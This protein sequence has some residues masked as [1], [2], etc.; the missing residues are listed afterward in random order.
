MNKMFRLSALLVAITAVALADST[1]RTVQY[2]AKDIVNIR[3]KVKYT[4]LIE[5][6]S[7]EKIMEAATGDK[8]FWI[9]DVVNT[10]FVLDGG[11]VGNY[12]GDA[13]SCANF[14]ILANGCADHEYRIRR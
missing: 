14:V 5:L 6:P 2:H 1:A 4:T 9:I 12:R 13:L 8:D 3:A 7:A 11:S 10:G